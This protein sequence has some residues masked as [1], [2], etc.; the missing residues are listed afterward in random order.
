MAEKPRP[1][2]VLDNEPIEQLSANLWTVGGAL[3]GMSLKRRM[4]LIRRPD[5]RI[6]IH[7]AIA[8]DD[9]SMEQIER[10]GEPAEL[11]VPNAWHRLDAN[12]YTQRYKRLRVFAAKQAVDRVSEQVR[13]HGTWQ[14]F[15]ADKTVSARPLPGA[16]RSGEAA[17]VVHDQGKT[18]LVF[19]DV[20][21]NH[22]HV[23]GSMGVVMRLLGSTGEAKVTRVAKWLMLSDASEFAAT[24]VQL[25]NLPGLSALIPGHG[26]PVL[27]NAAATLARAATRV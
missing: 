2:T 4:T 14:D 23:E 12:A 22:P 10:W 11:I 25:A 16:E 6:V 19:N 7:N 9:A 20:F 13:V 24:L 15:A 8:L 1:W 26:T 18:T 3:P 17:F 27:S 21:F 5:G